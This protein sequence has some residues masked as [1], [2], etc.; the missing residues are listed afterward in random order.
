MSQFKIRNGNNWYAVPA[1]G[2][3]VPSGG[4]AG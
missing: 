3:G 4:S 2:A 1:S